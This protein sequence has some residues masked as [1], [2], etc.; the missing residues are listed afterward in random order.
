MY[1][2]RTM[3]SDSDPEL[4]RLYVEAYMA[5][6]EAAMAEVQPGEPDDGVFKLAGDPRVTRVG[7]IL[8]RLSLD[9]LPQLWNVLRGDMSIVGPRPPLRYEVERYSEL[10]LGRLTTK[11]GLTGWWQVNGRCETTFEQMIEL[12]LAYIERQ[13]FVFDILILLKTI[14]AVFTGRG[15]G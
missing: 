3:I 1:K 2:F 15:A 5:G 14:P 10:E 13:S 9:E 7:S 6:D 11:P 8:R 4:H 12:D